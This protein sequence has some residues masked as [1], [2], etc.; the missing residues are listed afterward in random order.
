MSSFLNKLKEKTKATAASSVPATETVEKPTP[1]PVV[2]TSVA[3]V[4]P[5]SPPPVVEEKKEEKKKEKVKEEKKVKK[6]EKEVE[7]K[8]EKVK[9]ESD[10]IK[11]SS[12]YLKGFSKEEQQLLFSFLERIKENAKKAFSIPDDEVV[13]GKK[14]LRAYIIKEDDKNTT[15]QLSFE[16]SYDEGVVWPDPVNTGVRIC[17]AKR[18]NVLLKMNAFERHAYKDNVFEPEFEK[19]AKDQMIKNEILKQLK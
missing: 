14:K 10:S 1:A 4:D 18:L 13:K 6:E 16:A 15:N 17:D 11:S 2:E 12:L 5:P 19:G 8:E 9:E 3:D 7:K